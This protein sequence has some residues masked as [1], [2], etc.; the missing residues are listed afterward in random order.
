M[1]KP[2]LTCFKIR[3]RNKASSAENFLS[4]GGPKDY[5]EYREVCGLLR[6]LRSAH[7]IIE[8]LSRNYMDGDDD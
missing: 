2:S 6:G 4:S 3:S 5:S 8:D 1:A 7:A